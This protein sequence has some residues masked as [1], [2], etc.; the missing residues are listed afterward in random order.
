M[1][2]GRVTTRETPSANSRGLAPTTNFDSCLVHRRSQEGST[3]WPRLGHAA[4]CVSDEIVSRK[5]LPYF[6]LERVETNILVHD[7]LQRL[8]GSL[9]RQLAQGRWQSAPCATS[10]TT[11]SWCF[12]VSSSVRWS[13]GRFKNSSAGCSCS[14]APVVAVIRFSF[15]QSD[16]QCGSNQFHCIIVLPLLAKLFS[17]DFQTQ[18]Q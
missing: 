18:F 5:M 3:Q 9:I 1:R 11:L 16:F 15:V 8:R 13:T 14:I 12:G 7:I 6:F 17:N 2:F 4:I 10:V